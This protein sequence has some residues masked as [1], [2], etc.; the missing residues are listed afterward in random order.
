MCTIAYIKN[1]PRRVKQDIITYKEVVVISDYIIISKCRG[2]NYTL[3]ELYK[4]NI[5]AD[6]RSV[7]TISRHTDIEE[8]FIVRKRVGL[9]AP[10]LNISEGFHSFS[11]LERAKKSGPLIGA[12]V[13]CLIPAG[14][15]IVTGIDKGLIVSD[16]II[17]TDV[18]AR[19]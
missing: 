17:I 18:I 16:Q 5:V 14:S 7:D 4:T 8:Y 12:I 13:E 1:R 3:G 9:S 6:I 10:V 19:I 2:F 15:K 11:S